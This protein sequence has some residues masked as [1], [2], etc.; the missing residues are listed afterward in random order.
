M[1]KVAS[2]WPALS[3]QGVTGWWMCW[4]SA[5]PSCAVG[6]RNGIALITPLRADWAWWLQHVFIS[7]LLLV[8]L[9]K[10]LSFGLL[11]VNMTMNVSSGECRGG[12]C[13]W[14][15]WCTPQ[16][17]TLQKAAGEKRCAQGTLCLG[18]TQTLHSWCGG[19]G[20]C[21][22]FNHN[23]GAASARGKQSILLQMGWRKHADSLSWMHL[24]EE[25]VLWRDARGFREQVQWQ[26]DLSSGICWSRNH[27]GY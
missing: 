10:V 19:E 4:E 18:Q 21:P 5:V 3:V 23:P 24:F 15:P 9:L 26:H 12:L 6:N 25:E 27:C 2:S 8:S 1:L 11:R 17:K 16:S 13:S 7:D 20:G 14:L 22:E